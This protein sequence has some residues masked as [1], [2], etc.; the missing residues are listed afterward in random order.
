MVSGQELPP[1]APPGETYAPPGQVIVTPGGIG[2]PYA[3]VAPAAQTPSWWNYPSTLI[4]GLPKM[5]GVSGLAGPADRFWLRAE[6]LHWWTEGMDT[7]PLVTTSPAATPQNQAAV[8]GEPGTR[9]LSGGGEL[10]DDSKGGYRLRGGLWLTPQAAFGIEGEFFDLAE[11]DD[12]FSGSSDGST[13]LGRPFFDVTAGQETARLI[14]F[15]GVVSGNIRI[16]SETD[17][18]SALINGRAAL[19]PTCGGGPCQAYPTHDRV[20][21]I[22]GY[23]YLNLEDRLAFNETLVSQIPA[24]PGTIVSHESFQTENEFHGLQLGMVYQAN[25]RRVWLES[26]LRVAVGN[27]TQSVRIAGNTAITES[28]VT[29]NFRGGLL[30]QRT[31]IGTY[32][33]EEFTMIPEIGL[34]LG[35]RVFDWLHA[36]AGYTILYFP[37]VVRAG[38]QIDRDVNPNLLA[39]EADPFSGAL[40]PRFSFDETDYWA[41]GF[42]LGGEVRF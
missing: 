14:A 20:D 22:V 26:L 11:Q 13:I 37:N 12:G 17:L 8:L 1:Y 32:E 27:N 35:V 4:P 41:Q 10:N 5:R 9:T 2:D 25:F 31:N 3:S 7:P 34:T 19:C 21:W 18:T 28:G 23:R 38:N 16:A 29:E 6:Y 30:A 33:R 15:P 24:A 40:R 36:T 39:P 42:S